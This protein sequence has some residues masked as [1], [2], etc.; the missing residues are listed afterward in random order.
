MAEAEGPL[1]RIAERARARAQARRAVPQQGVELDV[2]RE[3]DSRA[4]SQDSSAEDVD[5]VTEQVALQQ[6]LDTVRRTLQE[7][8]RLVD[9][10]AAQCRR[11][12]DELEDQHL[13]YDGL[14][15]DLERKKLSFTET[16]DQLAR[17]TRDREEIEERY[18]ALLS[19]ERPAEIAVALASVDTPPMDKSGSAARFVGGLMAGVLLF[20]VVL[21]VWVQ[22]DP[23][24][25]DELWSAAG[26]ETGPST[27]VS[28]QAVPP[29]EAV[30]ETVPDHLSSLATASSAEDAIQAEDAEPAVQQEQPPPVVLGTVRDRLS[31]GSAGPVMVVLQGGDFT[32]GKQRI[33]PGD[34]A[35]PAHDVQL[36]GFLISATEVTFEDYDRFARASGRRLPDDFGWGRGDRPV[37]DVTWNDARVYA[38]WLSA[39]TGKGYRLPSEA[40]WEYAASAGERSPFW[41]GFQAEPERAV[42]FDCGTK[43]DNRSSAPVGSFG[44]N[45]LGLYDTAG[46]VMEWVDDCYHA[47]YTG[48]P[49]DG[50][51]WDEENCSF[52][53]ARGGAFNKPARSMHS[54]VRQHLAPDTRIN[55]L[56]FRLARDE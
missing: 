27:G 6:E 8:E 25:V 38:Q 31:D 49:L 23:S 16:R 24:S 43:W 39:R 44:P 42:C 55:A 26:R 45:P 17:V 13:A 28:S 37:V 22:L 32:M 51:P 15:Q 56:G 46:N 11:L 33:M 1:A 34:D 35:G 9:A 47:D 14:K 50:R 19:S 3:V 30:L 41:W 12:E 53:V 7:K 52:R 18:H 40:Q 4:E 36:G 54:T 29:A 2:S 5:T 20:A 48:A 10:M 21:G